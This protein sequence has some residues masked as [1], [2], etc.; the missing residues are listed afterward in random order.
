MQNSDDP[1][2]NVIPVSALTK[3]K[4]M[5]LLNGY[6]RVQGGCRALKDLQNLDDLFVLI[7]KE[8]RYFTLKGDTVQDL[9]TQTEDS[10]ESLC[11]V[12]IYDLFGLSDA[13]YRAIRKEFA[14]DGEYGVYI[15]EEGQFAIYVNMPDREA[16]YNDRRVQKSIL[17]T[18]AVGLGAATLSYWAGKRA[19]KEEELNLD[20]G[21]QKG[22]LGWVPEH[23]RRVFANRR[24]PDPP[25][26][27]PADSW[28]SD[29]G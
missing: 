8:N 19:G 15:K 12:L 27:S 4:A 28:D 17:A 10:G 25:I 22:Y 2:P 26:T 7:K 20:S 6:T 1:P 21:G 24:P 9:L 14:A 16:W 23:H 5:A 11:R 13:Q 29:D 3:A 18:G